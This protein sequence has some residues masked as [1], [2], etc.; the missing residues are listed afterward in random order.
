MRP[1]DYTLSFLDEIGPSPSD[2]TVEETW[3]DRVFPL[4]SPGT[5]EA[6]W[7]AVPDPCGWFL[8]SSRSRCR[9][10]PKPHHVANCQVDL[11]A[12]DGTS[13]P[14]TI[15]YEAV[16]FAKAAYLRQVLRGEA[17]VHAALARRRFVDQYV[18]K[19][20]AEWR[21]VIVH[22]GL[23]LYSDGRGG[24]MAP[25]SADIYQPLS[26][27][28]NIRLL[29]LLPAEDSTSML[30]CTLAESVCLPDVQYEAL[31]Y[32]WGEQL[33]DT[34]QPIQLN[35]F[36]FNVGKNLGGALRQ[37]RPQ[38]GGPR[39]LWIDAVC[40]DQTN[41]QER[42]QQVAQMDHV[43]RTAA[44]V[45]VWL[46]LEAGAT[47]GAFDGLA[48]GPASETQEF[49]ALLVNEA[50]LEFPFVSSRP[51]QPGPYDRYSH[52][53]PS[54]P[55][56]EGAIA[57]IQQTLRETPEPL[58]E[59]THTAK[60]CLRV[61]A[62]PWWRRVWVL[63]ELILARKATV[64]HG[65]GSMRWPLLQ[66]ILFLFARRRW[67]MEGFFI[68]SN[69]PSLRE[70]E[71]DLLLEL[72]AEIE[73]VF[74]FF[75]L[76]QSS[77]LASRIKPAS[78]ADLVTLTHKFEATDARDQV[79]AL[80][81][82]L[83]TESRERVI[84]TPN[85][86]TDARRL[87]V[88]TARYWLESTG[89]LDV[90]SA[91]ET[92]LRGSEGHG[93][94]R[95][96]LPSWAPDLIRPHIWQFC[97]ILI[98]SFSPYKPVWEYLVEKKAR[99]ESKSVCVSA[100]DQGAAAKNPDFST[101]Q[102]YNAGFHRQSPYPLEFAAYDEVF[103]PR[104]VTVDCIVEVGPMLR[105]PLAESGR[106]LFH[107]GRLEAAPAIV[108]ELM[109]TIQS[110]KSTARLSQPGT[111]PSTGEP[112]HEAFW[113]TIF[114][115]RYIT[116]ERAMDEPL[117]LARFGRCEG[118]NASGPAQFAGRFPPTNPLHERNMGLVL[119]MDTFLRGQFVKVNMF[120]FWMSMFRT[121]K[122]YIGVGHP[123]TQAGD[124][125]VVLLGSP[126]PLILRDYPEGYVIVGQSYVHGIMDGEIIAAKMSGD[127][128]VKKE[129]FE[130]F[131]LI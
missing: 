116:S 45:I 89:S 6:N 52:R 79:Y 72:S 12:H 17:H 5:F 61:L 51:G 67:G 88:R 109:E 76:Q 118:E 106:T 114:L 127:K 25:S 69:V 115:D 1:S 128:D 11:Q 26:Q 22:C 15:S 4:L 125:I 46:G 63:Q 55:T 58:P 21:E 103:L 80:V 64:E 31:S 101:L 30:Q 112:L 73:K 32:V 93:A 108:D 77:V 99:E 83:P 119:A 98:S 28:R 34:M 3:R 49:D 92:V 54:S 105:S 33:P 117:S 71:M 9:V 126:V 129:E 102:L 124:K 123:D 39:L 10:D 13:Y 16:V 57:M 104:G 40:I 50:T 14:A 74:P 24:P 130:Q 120:S 91:W 107:E 113:R 86:K 7:Q 110:W 43:Y 122:G 59:S 81:G 87:C 36:P 100:P 37:L 42:A 53:F 66:F 41:L 85:Y 82:L 38:A 23:H 44:N 111:Y 70:Q 8:D 19:L 56:A 96:A 94:Q 65:S 2:Q 62:Q 90:I 131:H 35:G 78:M 18:A 27:P 84:F 68:S 75:F 29:K 48:H 60:A 20:P 97:S 121:S 95:P 47:A